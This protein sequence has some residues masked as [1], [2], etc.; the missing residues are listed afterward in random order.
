MKIF[1][2]LGLALECAAFAIPEPQAKGKPCTLTLYTLPPTPT[3]WPQWPIKYAATS[4]RTVNVNCNGCKIA[5]LEMQMTM[6]FVPPL[7]TPWP[8]R[9]SPMAVVT[10]LLCTS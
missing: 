3:V 6:N 8:A 4:T 9:I 5:T 10:K 7:Q 1:T 2:I